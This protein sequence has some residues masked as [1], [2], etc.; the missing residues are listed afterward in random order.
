MGSV[1]SINTHILAEVPS[2]AGNSPQAPSSPVPSPFSHLS[3]GRP[4]EQLYY[5]VVVQINDMNIHTLVDVY[6]VIVM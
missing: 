3:F 2:A 4:Y 5:Y 6:A 1:R